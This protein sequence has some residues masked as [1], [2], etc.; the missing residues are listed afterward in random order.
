VTGPPLTMSAHAAHPLPAA[1]RSTDV[2]GHDPHKK[3]RSAFRATRACAHN[4]VV[5]DAQTMSRCPRCGSAAQVH[6]ISELADLARTSLARLQGQGPSSGQPQQG[7][8]AEPVAGPPPGPDGRRPGGLFGRGMS[9][10]GR[11][12]NDYD[13][14]LDSIGDAVADVALGAAAQFI[15]R[16]IK[17]RVEQTLT[18]RVMPAVGQAATAALQNQIAVAEKYPDL[19]ACLTDH[20]VFLAGRSLTQ[21]M[22]DLGKITVPQADALVAQ[23]QG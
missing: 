18:E 3:S 16:A 23:L 15:G 19:R 11:R 10:P 5:N 2:Y 20:V 4:N 1:L 17:R 8:E 9:V 7:W 21:P 13:S 22:P 12:T 6:S 14:P